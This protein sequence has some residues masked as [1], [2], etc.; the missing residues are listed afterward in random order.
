MR[1]LRLKMNRNL[2]MPPLK[3]LHIGICCRTCTGWRT[4]YL[5]A[6]DE[7]YGSW[8]FWI[9]IFLYGWIE[10]SQTAKREKPRSKCLI[11]QQDHHWKQSFLD[12]HWGARTS[13]QTISFFVELE[14]RIRVLLNRRFIPAKKSVVHLG[15]FSTDYH[16]NWTASVGGRKIALRAKRIGDTGIFYMMHPESWSPEGTDWPCFEWGCWSNE[17]HWFEFIFRQC[18]KAESS[19]GKDPIQT[20]IGEGYPQPWK[21]RLKTSFAFTLTGAFFCLFLYGAFFSPTT[22][23]WSKPSSRKLSSVVCKKAMSL[24]FH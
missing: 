4:G 18:V 24:F 11:H 23:R 12:L 9:W 10:P 8:S 17:Q 14:A 21:I 7:Q 2:L 15:D 19:T 5:K 13:D 22:I 3:G 1:I 20:K 16:L 6:M